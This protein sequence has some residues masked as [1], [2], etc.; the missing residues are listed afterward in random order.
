MFQALAL[1]ISLEYPGLLW[2]YLF[3]LNSLTGNKTYVVTS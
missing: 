1:H 2:Q 3:G